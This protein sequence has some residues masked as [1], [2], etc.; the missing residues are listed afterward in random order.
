LKKIGWGSNPQP[1]FLRSVNMQHRNKGFTLIELLI[2]ISIV[3]ILGAAMFPNLLGSR[4][5]TN[6][7]V[8][9]SVARRVLNT[10]AAVEIND[11][12]FSTASCSYTAPSVTVT[13]GSE[14]VAVNAPV[15]SV[16]AV[17]CAS[18]ANQYSVSVNYNFGTVASYSETIAK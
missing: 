3:A 12:T 1:S 2:V 5:R 15:S 8:A 16:T 6:D 11:T 10:M 18:T 17:S 13:S 9:Q 14:T 4:K 7:V